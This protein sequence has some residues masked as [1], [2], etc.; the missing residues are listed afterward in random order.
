MNIKDTQTPGARILAGSHEGIAGI[1]KMLQ[2]H[3]YRMKQQSPSDEIDPA[4]YLVTTKFQNRPLG[5]LDESSQRRLMLQKYGTTEDNIAFAAKYNYSTYKFIRNQ[6]VPNSNYA[7]RAKH[8]P[9]AVSFHDFPDTRDY[10][11]HITQMPHYHSIYLIAPRTREKYEQVAA[12]EF[13]RLHLNRNYSPI[14]TG[15]S[16]LA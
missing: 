12:R 1:Q 3:Y 8:H 10:Q 15:Q 2:E 7:S 16:L 11:P 6:I 9:I 4:L 5:S 14:I 13:D